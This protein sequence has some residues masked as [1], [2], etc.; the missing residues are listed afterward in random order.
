MG[1]RRTSHTE[2]RDGG[3]SA[4]RRVDRKPAGRIWLERASE[5]ARERGEGEGGRKG[6]RE[7]FVKLAPNC[8]GIPKNM[9]SGSRAPRAPGT[10]SGQMYQ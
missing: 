10:V 4:A 9:L 5:R 2:I 3:Y 8:P 7:E 1:G 6:G